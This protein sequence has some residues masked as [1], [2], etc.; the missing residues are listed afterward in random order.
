[1]PAKFIR[2]EVKN[3]AWA[4][5]PMMTRAEA[6]GAGYVSVTNIFDPS[7]EP[8]VVASIERSMKGVDAVWITETHA[9]RVVCEL[10]RKKGEVN[11][12]LEDAA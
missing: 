12:L 11:L 8:E 7:A 2:D 1:M 9:F 10:G 5:L 4:T 6:E 3:K